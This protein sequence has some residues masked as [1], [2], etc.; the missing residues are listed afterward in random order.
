MGFKEHDK[1]S[2]PPAI[3][4]QGRRGLL[5]GRHHNALLQF[6]TIVGIVYTSSCL[7][8]INWRITPQPKL[9]SNLNPQDIDPDTDYPLRPA[10]DPWDISTSYPYPRKLVKTV[11]EGTWLRITTHPRKPEIVFDMLGDLYCMSTEGD[12]SE[13]A[14]PLLVGI[15]YEKEAEFSSDGTRL[16]FISD[17]S[18]GVDNI[19]T[20]PYT[21][22]EDMGKRSMEQ[23]RKSTVQQTNST[24]RFFS[25]PAFHPT[26]AK[27]VATKR[28][29]TGRPNGAGEIWEFPLLENNT[30]RLPERG[31]KRII[32]RKLPPSWSAS[33]YPQSQLGS[34]QA[35]YTPS[36]DGIIFSRNIKD[37]MTGKFSYNKDVHAGISAVFIL[38]TTT[39]RTNE[40]VA[41]TQSEPNK[42]ASPGGANMPRLSSD[43]MTLAFVR[44]SGEKEVLA[45]K[46]MRS[47]TVHYVWDGL[48]YD[49]ST[50]PA[51]MGAYPNYGWADNDTSIIIWSQGKIWKVPIGT[52]GL[53]ERIANGHARQLPFS[54]TINLDLGA[55]RF[56]ETKIKDRELS[57]FRR[58]YA[59]RR[60]RSN[61]A[62]DE[63]VF[64]ASGDTYMYSPQAGTLLELP[65]PDI[66]TS[67]YSPS[68]IAGS[69]YIIQACWDNHNLT[70]FHLT[71]RKGMSLLPLEGVPRGRHISPVSD[72]TYI[73]YVRTG[74]DYMFGDVEETF[75]E[76]VWIGKIQLPSA[77]GSD[78]AKV[79]D[80]HRL[81]DVD[82]GPETTLNIHT[83]SSRNILLI[84]Q[85][86]SVIEY[87]IKTSQF[88]RTASGK[89]SVEMRAH[90]EGYSYI[91]FRDFQHIWLSNGS[92][93]GLPDL[94]SKP[95]DLQ[96]PEN[97]IRLSQVGGH[98]VNL[99]GD[100]KLVMWFLGPTLHYARIKDILAA[101]Q[102]APLALR[103][104]GQC[105]ESVIHTSTLNVTYETALS[106]Q[107]RFANDK[108]FAIVNATLVSM[109]HKEEQLIKNATIVVHRGEIKASGPGVHMDIPTDAEV[110]NVQGGVVLPGFVDV[111]GH[112]GG[113]I[114]PYPLQ[115]W[116]METFLGYGVTT[117]HNP[118]SKNVAGHVERNLI[119]KGRMYGPRVFHT[120][121]VLYGSVQ[122]P[123]YTEINSLQDARD[124]LLRVKKEGGEDSFSVKNY[125]L[126]ARSAR[127]RLL[128][129]ASKLDM[130]VVPEGGWS[131][132]WGLT[133]FIDGYTSQEHPLPVPELYD[134]V[135]S[136]VEASGSSYTPLAVMNY[137]GIFGQHW[138]H[139]TFNIPEDPKLRRYVKHDILESLTEVKQAPKSSYL[140][141]NTTISTAKLAKRGV[142]TNVGAH[143][144]Q[145]IGFL[146]HSEMLMMAM[147]GQEPYEVLRHATIGGATSL[148]LNA[149]AGSIEPGKLADLVIYPPSVDSIDKA[150]GNS[151]HMEYVMRGGTL[152]SVEDGLVEMWP[153]R[154]RR[155]ERPYMN[156]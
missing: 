149:S 17:A 46:D 89:A 107:T 97:L 91:V 129:E 1:V 31:G 5:N 95:G 153:R 82:S 155:Q 139:Q 71:S 96:T 54:A 128:L 35:R 65:R 114:S 150:W 27:I 26:E 3:S 135:L 138:V 63:V 9:L 57:N 106:H 113:F 99:S 92:Q 156:P 152:F 76:G 6:F 28:F 62:G 2:R 53:G 37:D 137:G 144:E 72:G 78:H 148:G 103:D 132:D 66:S 25:S 70:T 94:W 124:A 126:S 18:F 21:G 42:P 142:R 104:T 100:G 109:D 154:G 69:Q 23:R 88:E 4:L 108:S 51:F 116:E 79:T 20:M 29:L 120:G 13:I 125:Q 24:F 83:L 32:H 87:D 60:L 38:N 11:S 52:N 47:G 141:F 33:Q 7:W 81:P 101:C 40:V 68:F 61:M 44:R 136:L 143:G 41:A 50:I 8:R 115:S 121:D 22:C 67:C 140:F 77:S 74:K 75:G 49:L 122:P 98:D 111:H 43:G 56:S 59:F 146:Y 12:G 64:E 133:Y 118:A 85:P 84:N 151:M 15:P 73:A 123:V 127:Q 10:Q 105:A 58:E 86:D 36:G 147:G 30:G 19:W 34:E 112:W 14:I 117:I 90:V 48:S 102:G 145:P 119:E 45:L 134:D 80:L 130:L 110:L 93:K 39:G 131:F 55:T 16:V